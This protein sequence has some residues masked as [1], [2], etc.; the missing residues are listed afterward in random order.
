MAGE[1]GLAPFAARHHLRSLPLL[2]PLVANRLIHAIQRRRRVHFLPTSAY[3]TPL[4][5]I[6]RLQMEAI[7]RI[8]L[9]GRQPQAMGD[10]GHKAFDPLV[11][12]QVR[13]AVDGDEF[14]TSWQLASTSTA[15]LLAAPAR[16]MR[17]CSVPPVTGLAVL[18][19]SS[20]TIRI[21]SSRARS[22]REGSRC[23]LLSM[24][25]SSGD[26]S[27]RQI[28]VDQRLRQLT[29]ADAQ[30][31]DGHALGLEGIHLLVDE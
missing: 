24:V 7:V 19:S 21:P 22:N 14:L 3:S 16:Y 29:H 17:P 23:L 10:A 9:Q 25:A 13:T 20:A 5:D 1:A 6:I 30:A 31:D 4:T 28:T 26:I 18:P 11:G 8:H 27:P 15:T 2:D 12:R